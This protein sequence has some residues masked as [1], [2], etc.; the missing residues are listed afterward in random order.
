MATYTWEEYTKLRKQHDS[1]MKC[2]TAI[3]SK[4]N[5][6]AYYAVCKSFKDNPDIKTITYSRPVI[7]LETF[8]NDKDFINYLKSSETNYPW[9]YWPEIGWFAF[10][11]DKNSFNTFIN[12]NSN[13]KDGII[14]NFVSAEVYE[15]C[16]ELTKK[17]NSKVKVWFDK[18]IF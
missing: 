4:N 14:S 6:G 9:G 13:L 18:I 17:D 11:R 3:D 16:A 12:S 2:F 7:T 8:M 10:F 5:I 15:N 1:E